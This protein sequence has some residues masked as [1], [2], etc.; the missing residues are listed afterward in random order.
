AAHRREGASWLKAAVALQR[1]QAEDL[2]HADVPVDWLLREFGRRTGT[3]DAAAPVVFTSAVGVG[4]ATLAGPDTGF[5][6]KVWGISQ[7]PQVCLDNQVTEE[8]GNLVV[9]WD[10]VESLFPEG[11]LDAMFDAHARLLRHLVTGDWEAPLPDPV[12]AAQLERRAAVAREAAGRPVA[13]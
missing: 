11:V 8:S 4:D 2:D 9:T 5:P 1:R 7:S 12:P 3:V 10:A 13:P 6:A